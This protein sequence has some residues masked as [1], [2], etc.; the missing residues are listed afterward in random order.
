MSKTPLC[1][2]VIS[3]EVSPDEIQS[4]KTLLAMESIEVQK[5]QNRLV[6][7]DDIAYV[8]TLVGLVTGL[9]QLA[10]CGIKTA[11]TIN[12]WRRKLREKGKEPKA[13]LEHPERSPLELSIASDEEVEDWFKL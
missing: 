2:I 3:S 1:S 8:A 12:N 5:P 6:G 7:A 4:L 13:K 9:F 10:E 11:K